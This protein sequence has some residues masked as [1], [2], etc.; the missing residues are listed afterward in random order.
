MSDSDSDKAV[1]RR[2]GPVDNLT[3]VRQSKRGKIAEQPLELEVQLDLHDCAEEIIIAWSND[4]YM[5]LL[6]VTEFD[7]EIN[8][9]KIPR[10][11]ITLLR[12]VL[13]AFSSETLIGIFGR[14]LVFDKTLATAPK[15]SII[16]PWDYIAERFFQSTNASAL[17]WKYTTL[18]KNYD[19]SHIRLGGHKLKLIT[20]LNEIF[21]LAPNV[22]RTNLR[23]SLAWLKDKKSGKYMVWAR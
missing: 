17:K 5:E 6:R 18:L 10:L 12:E 7:T 20:V 22:P 23:N 19:L 1:K 4:M 11:P 14:N 13:E 3:P 8:K 15:Q 16:P 2:L 9:E 21:Q